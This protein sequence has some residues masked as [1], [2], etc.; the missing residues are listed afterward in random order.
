MAWCSCSDGV[1]LLW[2]S[3]DIFITVEGGSRAVWG[4]W[5]AAVVW[6][7]YFDFGLK[8]KMIGRSIAER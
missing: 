8:G 1:V 6:I 5:S 4:G 3:D 7:Q 2:S